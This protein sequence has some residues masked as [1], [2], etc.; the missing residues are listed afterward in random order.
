[1]L[2]S[3]AKLWMRNTFVELLLSVDSKSSRLHSIS[4]SLC[5]AGI[6]VI[7]ELRMHSDNSWSHVLTLQRGACLSSSFTLQHQCSA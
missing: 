7:I 5:E 6:A 4:V 1:M 2:T 3:L